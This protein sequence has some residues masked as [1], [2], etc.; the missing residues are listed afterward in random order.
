M[1]QTNHPLR[2]KLGMGG[3][4]WLWMH[5]VQSELFS[6]DLGANVGEFTLAVAAMGGKVIAVDAVLTNLAYIR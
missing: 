4:A 5:I 2:V 6:L 1:K 3:G